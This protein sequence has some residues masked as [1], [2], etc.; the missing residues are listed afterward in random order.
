[1]KAYI[2][3]DLKLHTIEVTETPKQWIFNGCDL[4]GTGNR[5]CSAVGYRV[6]FA[7]GD[8]LY[9]LRRTF[10]PWKMTAEA[11]IQ[12][13]LNRLNRTIER[14]KDRIADAEAQIKKVAEALHRL[15]AC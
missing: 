4:C 1:M 14:S 2:Y 12:A 5:A 11:A 7:K 10:I 6:R 13:E 3:L 9:P 15:T 8:P